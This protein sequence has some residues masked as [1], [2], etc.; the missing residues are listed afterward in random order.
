MSAVLPLSMLEIHP[1]VMPVYRNERIRSFAMW[2]Q[3]NDH[4]LTA[5]YNVLKPYCEEGVEPLVDYFEFVA[6]QHEREELKQ[7]SERVP[8]GASL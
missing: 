1:I 5:Y 3:D 8:H 2:L 6:I 4:A 7:L